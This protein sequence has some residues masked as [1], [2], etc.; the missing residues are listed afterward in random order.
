VVNSTPAAT[1]SVFAIA[2]TP[3]TQS[4]QIDEAALRAH[5]ERL[6]QA[7]VGIYLAGGGSGEAYSLTAEERS[8]VVRIG[9]SQVRG[10]TPVRAM[11]IEPHTIEEM[12]DFAYAAADAG[13]EAI[14]V[15]SLDLGHGR[16]PSASEVR[17]Y[18]HTVARHVNAPLVL[19]IHQRAAGYTPPAALIAD[20]CNQYEHIVGLN[21]THSDFGYLDKLISARPEHVD[22]HVGGPNQAVMALM[23]GATGFLS[24][25]ANVAPR[26][27]RSVADSFHSGR[28]DQLADRYVR[29]LRLSEAIYRLGGVRATKAALRYLGL[30]GGYPRPPRLDA[31]EDETSEIQKTLEQ[32]DIAA[33]E[34]LDPANAMR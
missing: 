33:C 31:T 23:A 8:R 22:I 20:L 29:L 25:E 2:I 12:L 27:C 17:H 15:Y 9:V 3:F 21:I 11:G 30:P 10:R 28:L 26:L 16:G 19:S 34:G 14:Q 5:V 7:N 18:L 32:L 6:A 4:G 1:A 13:A 24:T